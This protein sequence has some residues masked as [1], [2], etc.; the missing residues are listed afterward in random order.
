MTLNINLGDFNL[1]LLI[2]LVAVALAIAAVLSTPSLLHAVALHCLVRR[3]A[4][5]AHRRIVAQ[6]K[7]RW[8]R[9]IAYEEDRESQPEPEFRS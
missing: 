9:E 3:D 7:V 4:L 1:L 2:L 8:D 5:L 6:L